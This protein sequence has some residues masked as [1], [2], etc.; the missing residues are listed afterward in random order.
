VLHVRGQTVLNTARYVRERYGEDAHARLVA[1]LDPTTAATFLVPPRDAAWKPLAHA[2]SYMKAAR[3]ALAPSDEGFYR[4]MGRFSGQA[5]GQ[6]AF[7]FLIG[8]DPNTAVGR[9]A[10]MWRF[11]YDAG[12]VEVVAREPFAITIRIVGFD[13]GDR[14]WCER[15]E[16]FLEAVVAIAGGATPRVRHVGCVA[17]GAPHCELCGTWS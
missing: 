2:V 7:R 17:D 10:F 5:T 11:L 6:S 4:D 3:E 14:A 13:P 12:R 8:G 15:I 1:G 16:G 9:A